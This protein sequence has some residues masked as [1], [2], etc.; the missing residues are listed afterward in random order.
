[1]WIILRDIHKFIGHCLIPLNPCRQTPVYT[2]H[3][4]KHTH[5]QTNTHTHNHKH[6]NTTNHTQQQNKDVRFFWTRFQRQRLRKFCLDGLLLFTSAKSSHPS[7]TFLRGGEGKWIVNNTYLILSSRVLTFVGLESWGFN[8]WWVVQTLFKLFQ[9]YFF[10][11]LAFQ[12]GKYS[13]NKL[14]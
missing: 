1:M 8:S 11:L 3:K 12:N 9:Q 4:T 10:L 14:K 2:Q 13:L 7:V 6:T 5:T